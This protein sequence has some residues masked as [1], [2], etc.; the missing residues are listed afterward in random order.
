MKLNFKKAVSDVLSLK[1]YWIYIFLAA[2]VATLSSIFQSAKGLP[3]HD[4][5]SNVISIF[6]YISTGYLL[7]MINNLLNNKELNNA[8]ENF[9]QNFW[10]STKNGFKCFFGTLLNTVI[11]FSAGAIVALMVVLVF[12]AITRIAVNEQNILSFPA[13]KVALGLLAIILI[14]LMLFVLKLLPI[15][16]SENF[17]IKAMFCWRKVFK[18]FFQE[19]KTKKTLAILGIYILVELAIFLTLFLTMVIFNLIF[20]YTVKTLLVNHYVLTAFIINL[21]A[22][23]VPFIISIAHF[24]L[25]SLIYH[26]LTDVYK[27]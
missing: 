11:I 2:I 27:N 13:L 25:M 6:T 5:I 3:F 9:L 15:A 23:A 14:I 20:M 8:D 4:A 26:M 7:I 16:Y 19:G 22:V 17:S 21:S 18:E 24:M 12:M 10:N 1:Y